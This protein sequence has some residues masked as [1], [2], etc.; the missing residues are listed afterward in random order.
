MA[1]SSRRA[2]DGTRAVSRALLVSALRIALLVLSVFIL[3]TVA[4]LWWARGTLKVA[5]HETAA[6]A[7][8][9]ADRRI[10]ETGYFQIEKVTVRGTRVVPTERI[11]K[12]L[13]LPKKDLWQP[14][15]IPALRIEQLPGILEARVNR[16]LPDEIVVSVLEAAPVGWISGDSTKRTLLLSSGEVVTDPANTEDL[17]GLPRITAL[18]DTA[19]GAITALHHLAESGLPWAHDLR[20]EFTSDGDVRVTLPSGTIVIL[21]PGPTPPTASLLEAV[22]ADRATADTTGRTQDLVVD[23]RFDDQIIVRTR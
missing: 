8:A 5:I 15:R 23:L 12:A 2:L 13:E 6:D 9:W 22:L 19:P 1:S 20:A 18:G 14:L 4:T 16:R 17:L 3:G 7:M 11:I 10:E 21:P